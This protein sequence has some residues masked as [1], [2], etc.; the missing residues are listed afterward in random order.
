MNEHFDYI[1]VGAGPAG[2]QLGYFLKSAGRSY[3][4]LEAGGSPGTSF[5]RFPRH[6]KLISINKIHTGYDDVETN[7][8]WDWNSLLSDSEGY[9][10]N[11]YSK[12]YFPSADDLVTYLGGYAT[13]YDLNIR[14]GTKVEKVTKHG[15]FKIF[16]EKRDTYSC[17]RLIVASGFS[18]PYMPDIP[19]LELAENYTDVSVDAEDFVNQ[20]ILIIGKGNSGFETADHLIST[21]AVIHIVSPQAL[22]FAWKSHY[23]GDL[24]AINNNFLDTYQLKSQNAILDA[25]IQKIQIKGG[26][27]IV[28]VVYAHAHGETE[29]LIYDRVISC[30]GF[31]FDNSIFDESCHPQQ[32]IKDRF[33]A[34]T[35]TWESTNVEDLYF[36]GVLMQMRDLKKATSGFI[37]GFRYNVRILHKILENRYHSKTYDYNEFDATSDALTMAVIDRINQTSALWQQFGFVCDLI[38]VSGG[39]AKHYEEFTCDYVRDSLFGQNE[40]YFMLTLEFGKVTGDPFAIDRNPTPNMAK[41]SVFLHPVVRHY[42]KS[43]L[44]G[45][46]HLLEDLDAVWDKELAHI[47]PLRNFFKKELSSTVISNSKVRGNNET[48]EYV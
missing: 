48:E 33:P 28:S 21:A 27:Y 43:T 47:Q 3:I 41:E 37:H 14:Y 20:K 12:S 15:D 34:Q 7:L 46:I 18:K 5:K 30:T 19:G 17:R 26:K 1:I 24:R 8:R 23:V 40:N 11:Q 13:R 39:Q 25:S 45:K 9:L 29:N 42:R 38:I 31:R 16:D 32:A 10:F 22:T 44:L 35:S 4:I 6:R 2:L 36:A